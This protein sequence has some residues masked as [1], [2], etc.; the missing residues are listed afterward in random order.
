LGSI[1][2]EFDDRFQQHFVATPEFARLLS[3]ECMIIAGGKGSG[4]TAIMRALYDIEA[5]RTRYT[6]VYPVKLDQIKFGQLFAAIK[7]LDDASKHGVVAIARTTWQ[8]VIAIFI[9]ESVLKEKLLQSRQ[10]GEIRKYLSENGYLNAT[11]SDQL[12][13][14]L[15]RVWRLISKLSDDS[16][17]SET[18]PLLGLR[19]RQQKAI[20]AFP[21]D[22]TLD[23]FLSLALDAI[24]SSGKRLM[25]CLDGL[26]SVVEYS[27]GSR[28]YIFAGLIDAIYKCATHPKLKGAVV[29][30]ALIPKELAHGARALLRDLDKINQYMASVHWDSDNLSAFIRRRLEEYVKTKGR[31]FD[32]IW[33]EF[34]PDRIRNDMHGM[35]EDSYNYLLRHTLYRPRQLLIHVQNILNEWDLRSVHAPFKVDPTFIPKI[36]A[37]TNF[38]LAEFVVNELAL[39]F[40]SLNEFLKCFRGLPS[41]MPWSELS[42][43]IERYL[44]ASPDKVGEIFTDLYNYGFFGVSHMQAGTDGKKPYAQ[45]RFGF[46]NRKVER[47]VAGGLE[48]RSLIALAPVFVEYCG[49]KPSPFGII[50]PYV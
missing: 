32:E 6:A 12:L 49:C 9:L 3:D 4:K 48:D 33:R 30:K 42:N 44:G 1:S 40:S 39:D 20:T 2:A 27:V 24:R 45:F 34:F 17:A 47:N 11:A 13:G 36:V 37:D 7:R 23:K 35:E 16:E 19:A 26:D 14:H 43:R 31:P 50:T 29:I 41:V 38:E 18:N 22:Q 46:M 8:N 25:I 28:D 5:Y 15:E 10:R 21:S